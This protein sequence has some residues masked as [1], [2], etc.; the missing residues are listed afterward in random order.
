[1]CQPRG[2]RL[3]I[4]CPPALQAASLF[5]VTYVVLSHPLSMYENFDLN[6]VWRVRAGEFV[7]EMERGNASPGQSSVIHYSCHHIW[8]AVPEQRQ[9]PSTHKLFI[10]LVIE[11]YWVVWP[12]Y[13][14]RRLLGIVTFRQGATGAYHEGSFLV[15]GGTDFVEV[16][17]VLDMIGGVRRRMM[18]FL[19]NFVTPFYRTS[20]MLFL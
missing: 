13:F 5:Q 16:N 19:K 11:I 20:T 6:V 4:P 18:F 9:Q 1:M 7:S 17:S 8:G 10:T 15:L 12:R 2:W 14:P 3:S